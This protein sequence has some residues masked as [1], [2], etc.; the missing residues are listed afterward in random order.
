M[1]KNAKNERKI[2]EI[3]FFYEISSPKLTQHLCSDY[4]LAEM[5]YSAYE[6]YCKTVKA[7]DKWFGFHPW[8][9]RV[10]SS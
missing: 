3:R 8:N 7:R 2:F 9:N 1:T 4:R 5:M 10:I 6:N